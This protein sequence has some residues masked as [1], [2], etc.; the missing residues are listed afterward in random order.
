MSQNRSFNS[1]SLVSFLRVFWWALHGFLWTCSVVFVLQKCFLFLFN[2][3]GSDLCEIWCICLK[4]SQLSIITHFTSMMFKHCVEGSQAS[5]PKPTAP[6]S[7]TNAP[8]VI[9]MAP[10]CASVWFSRPAQQRLCWYRFRCFFYIFTWIVFFFKVYQTNCAKSLPVLPLHLRL[11]CGPQQ[12]QHHEVCR[13]H[14]SGRTH[15]QRWRGS[16]Q[17]G[18]S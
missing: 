15:P 8:S 2:E 9:R 4:R 11:H 6:V 16:L 10:S 12:K 5:P 1:I 3:S 14:Q 13:W 17:R 7:D 18:A